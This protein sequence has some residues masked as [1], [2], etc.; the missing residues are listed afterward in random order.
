M[1]K[2]EEERKKGERIWQDKIRHIDGELLLKR[3]EEERK[4]LIIREKEKELKLN[5]IRIK[6]LRK[7]VKQNI[8]A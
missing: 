3:Q 2:L 6:E 8:I 5:E 4:L 1:R 7:L